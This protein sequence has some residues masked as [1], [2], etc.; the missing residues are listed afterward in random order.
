MPKIMAYLF[1]DFTKHWFQVSDL[2][3][4]FDLQLKLAVY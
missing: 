1:D 4:G 2:R 3:D